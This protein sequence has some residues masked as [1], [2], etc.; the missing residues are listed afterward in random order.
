[1]SLFRVVDNQLDFREGTLPP[2]LFICLELI[3]GGP[4]LENI[5]FDLVAQDGSARGMYVYI[6]TTSTSSNTFLYGTS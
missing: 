2:I 1:M 4:L 6:Q 5:I 3:S